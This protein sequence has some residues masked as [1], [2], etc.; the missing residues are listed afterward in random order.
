MSVDEHKWF[1]CFFIQFGL[2]IHW[3]GLISGLRFAREISTIVFVVGK[4]GTFIRSFVREQYEGLG[5]NPFRM[6]SSSR[7]VLCV[8]PWIEPRM[9]P[10]SNYLFMTR[11][12]LVFMFAFFINDVMCDVFETWV[13]VSSCVPMEACQVLLRCHQFSMDWT[14]VL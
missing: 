6:K 11:C 9:A 2:F 14:L 10:A 1:S 7:I 8:M 4:A 5:P 12:G 3:L 13:S